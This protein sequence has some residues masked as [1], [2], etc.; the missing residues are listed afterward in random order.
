MFTGA[1]RGLMA[2]NGRAWLNL[3]PLT[4]PWIQDMFSPETGQILDDV[5]AY[6]N[7]DKIMLVAT[8]YDNPY[9]TSEGRDAYIRLL[10][11]DEK[12]CRVTGIPSAYSGIVY[13][14]FEQAV[15]MP[16]E[17]PVGWAD[18]L[19]HPTLIRFASP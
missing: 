2:R 17:H 3:T 4:E 14:E 18:W 12:D 7:D 13:K 15:H 19:P 10:T 16:K 1:A 11:D 6:I 8:M 5:G 9:L